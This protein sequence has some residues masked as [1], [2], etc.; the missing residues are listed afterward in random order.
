MNALII[1]DGKHGSTLEIANA[2]QRELSARGILTTVARPAEAPAPTPFDVVI[3]GSAIYMGRWMESMRQFVATHEPTLRSK[4][5]Y[6][7]SSGPLG[8]TKATTDDI[9]DARTIMQKTG[10][11]EHA[12]FSGRLDNAGLSLAEKAVVRMVKAPYGDYRAWQDIAAW[13]ARIARETLPQEA[14]RWA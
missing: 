1:V 13:A 11:R 3:L 6:V 4:P 9:P 5:V 2:I 8:D 14:T 10:A 7:F 12:V